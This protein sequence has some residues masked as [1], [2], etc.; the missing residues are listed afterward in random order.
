M[1]MLGLMTVSYAAEQ[2]NVPSSQPPMP[3]Q[4]PVPQEQPEDQR[5]PLSEAWNDIKPTVQQIGSEA[6]NGSKEVA[7]VAKGVAKKVSRLWK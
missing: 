6:A 3:Q 4:Q 1:W 2:E 7:N 5:P